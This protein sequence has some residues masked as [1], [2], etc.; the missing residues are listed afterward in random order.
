VLS[1]NEV[2]T[3]MKIIASN[4]RHRRAGMEASRRWRDRFTAE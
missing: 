1:L 2:N 3:A 4:H